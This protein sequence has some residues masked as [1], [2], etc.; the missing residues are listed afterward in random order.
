MTFRKHCLALMA[1]KDA[2]RVDILQFIVDLVPPFP[3]SIDLV[4]EPVLAD[5]IVCMGGRYAISVHLDDV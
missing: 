1:Y 5:M 4:L 2:R 3:L